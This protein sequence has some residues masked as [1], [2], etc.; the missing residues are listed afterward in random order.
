[1]LKK[2]P[3]VVYLDIGLVGSFVEWVEKSTEKNYKYL[4]YVPLNSF[5]PK[6]VILEQAIH[7][8]N[9]HSLNAS[10]GIKGIEKEIKLIYTGESGSIVRGILDSDNEKTIKE[11]REK[12]RQ[13]KM[14]VAS[15]KQSESDARSGV[16]KTISEIKNVNKSRNPYGFEDGSY[17]NNNRMNQPNDYNDNNNNDF[18]F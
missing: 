8:D 10:S 6:P 4:K 5:P 16:Q 17:G 14:S 1:M 15:L 11:L 2:S 9:I 7:N 13:L 18:A 12:I 3:L